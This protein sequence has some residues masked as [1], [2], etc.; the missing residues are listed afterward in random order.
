MKDKLK[1]ALLNPIWLNHK[2]G[3]IYSMDGNKGWKI[4]YY[5]LFESHKG[6]PYEEPRALIEKPIIGKL[7]QVIGTDF[8]KVPL[9]YLK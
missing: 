8:R 4:A 2:I 5:P 9:R 7:G 3:T 6:E 1:A